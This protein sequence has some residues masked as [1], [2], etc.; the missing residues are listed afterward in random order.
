[1]NEWG[2][3]VGSLAHWQV[4]GAMGYGLKEG[5]S[6]LHEQWPFWGGACGLGVAQASSMWGGGRGSGGADSPGPVPSSHSLLG[7]PPIT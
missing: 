7:D 4:T 6:S 5:Q 1:M 3:G 2:G